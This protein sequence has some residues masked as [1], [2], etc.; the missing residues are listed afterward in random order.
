M[1]ITETIYQKCLSCHKIHKMTKHRI[2]IQCMCNGTM[3]EY[4]IEREIRKM[5][6]DKIGI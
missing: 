1:N 3:F 2:V 5:K 6:L 4:Y